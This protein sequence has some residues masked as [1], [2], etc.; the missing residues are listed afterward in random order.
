MGD[1]SHKAG[2]R[3]GRPEVESGCPGEGGADRGRNLF[4]NRA[5]GKVT[6]KSWQLSGW[7]GRKEA[8]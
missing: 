6:G 8:L 1:G 4:E 2:T 3:A 5:N 7:V